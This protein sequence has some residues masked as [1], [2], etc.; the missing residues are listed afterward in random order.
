MIRASDYEERSHDQAGRGAPHRAGRPGNVMAA[1]EDSSLSE[2]SF[3]EKAQEAAEDSFDDEA[4]VKEELEEAFEIQKKAKQDAKKAFRNYKDS[5]RRVREIR[6]DRQPYM[7]VVAIPPP[8]P[9]QAP[10]MEGLPVQ[11]T[12]KYDKKNSR[13][14]SG[15]PK[16]RSKGRKEDVSMVDVEVVPEFSYMVT[17][18]VEQD[19]EF[20][21][22]A[23]TVPAGLAVIDT[24][25]TTSVIAVET[26]QR[27]REYFKTRG[28]PEP[29]A[30]VLPPVQLKGFNGVRTS[31]DRGL[32]WMV[33]LGKLWG[34]I[35]TYTV[36]GS[37]PFLLSRKVLQ[38]MGATLDLGRCTMTSRKHGIQDE[39]LMQAS[40]GHLLMPLVPPDDGEDLLQ[41]H[42]QPVDKETRILTEPVNPRAAEVEGVLPHVEVE[43]P[44]PKPEV[45]APTPKPEVKAPTPKP[46][47]SESFKKRHFQ[48]V[49]KNTRYTQ[50]DVGSLRYQLRMLFGGD[51]DFALCAYRP[52][53]ERVPKQAATHH[54]QVSVAHL[55]PRGTLE[56]TPWTDREPVA[57]R[58]EFDCPGACIFGYRYAAAPQA[59]DDQGCTVSGVSGVTE[60][61][62]CAET[63][64]GI[65]NSSVRPSTVPAASESPADVP[66]A[67]SDV[68]GSSHNL[69]SRPQELEAMYE[70]LDW[71]SLE[72]IPVPAAV[73]SRIAHQV[74]SVRRVPFQLA[75][76]ALREQPEE[77]RSELIA[78]LGEQ[79]PKLN[80]T[81]GLVEI[82]TGPSRLSH[83]CEKLRGLASIHLGS[84][85]GQDFTRAKDRRLLL[86]L[87]GCVRPRDVWFSWPSGCWS[88]RYGTDIARDG[89][90]AGAVLAARQKGRPFLRLFEQAWA[91]Q[92]MQGGHAHA[93]NPL[94]SLAWNEIT[95]GPAYEVD[96]D[97]CSLGLKDPHSQAAIQGTTRW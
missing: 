37:A 19:E 87:I 33:K 22:C 55:D 75:L 41:V 78:W 13:K 7:P 52:R 44:T 35:T 17:E 46:G 31:T 63:T 15:R 60:P 64:G 68:D 40:N 76:A 53:Y 61:K 26:A 29:T 6:K 25:C 45:K 20:E 56:I 48:T 50:V 71:V 81:V 90:A 34:Q 95:L 57:R 92:T 91:L 80:R 59:V 3:S 4:E 39:P 14:D 42:V 86:L 88:N 69:T 5:R 96:V 93:V 72:H 9:N 38:G 24:G 8:G 16:G 67:E 30:V 23:V 65:C 11:P 21:I 2:P 85:F 27:Y 89:A 79:S 84:Q 70:E 74:E 77:V 36:D 51:V 1:E 10:P 54:M 73:R 62:Q 12:F 28:L 49:M 97:M 83:Q 66:S 18:D 82:V 43:A 32:R 94:D 58:A 47:C